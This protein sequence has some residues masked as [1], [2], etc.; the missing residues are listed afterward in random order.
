MIRFMCVGIVVLTV[1]LHWLFLYSFYIEQILFCFKPVLNMKILEKSTTLKVV[2]QN[3]T[4][5]VE[6][7]G[8]LIACGDC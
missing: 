3:Y 5:C 8:P 4:I 6:I 7:G 1:K 2:P